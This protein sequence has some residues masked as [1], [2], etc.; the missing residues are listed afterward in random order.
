MQL[1][2]I[3]S[4]A[5]S[6]A[7]L[8]LPIIIHAQTFNPTKSVNSHPPESHQRSTNPSAS[9]NLTLR[10]FTSPQDSCDYTAT[11]RALTFTTAS[12]PGLFHCFDIASLFSGNSTSGF[13]NQSANFPG[14][15]GEHGIHW[16]LLNAESYNASANY[17]SV[18]Y[19]QHIS[20]PN[21]KTQEPGGRADRRTTL[22]GGK[23]CSEK[24]PNN[25]KG[26]LPWYGFSCLSEDK[27]SCGTAGYGFQSFTVQPAGQEKCWDFA[28]YGQNGAGR[29]AGSGMM[30]LLGTGVAVWFAL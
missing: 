14:V 24:D 30:A 22:Y 27:G 4:R 26:L 19:R 10:F 28:E 17:S 7:L 29:L 3:T 1:L 23:R 21:D 25:D 11:N 9:Q 20:S 2:T 8:L 13:V 6:L 16:S 5:A 12:I 18:L 15:S